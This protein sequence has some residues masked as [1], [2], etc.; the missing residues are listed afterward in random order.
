MTFLWE[1]TKRKKA[2]FTSTED[3]KTLVNSKL[4]SSCLKASSGEE[5]THLSS[6]K[7]T[8]PIYFRKMSTAKGSSS[9]IAQV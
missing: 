2:Q 6:I 3:V 9:K 1:F 7:S 4:T 5:D 8:R